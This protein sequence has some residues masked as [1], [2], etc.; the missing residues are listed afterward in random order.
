MDDDGFEYR[1]WQKTIN[2]G[3]VNNGSGRTRGEAEEWGRIMR[4]NGWKVRFDRRPRP[5]EWKRVKL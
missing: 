1:C 4:K 5:A 2:I 3:W